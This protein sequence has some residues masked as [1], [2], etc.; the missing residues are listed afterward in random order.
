MADQS[1]DRMQASRISGKD[2]GPNHRRNN[3]RSNDR[4]GNGFHNN[5]DQANRQII[6]SLIQ[7]P[8]ISQTVLADQ[9]GLSQSSV[10]VRL[11]KLNQSRLVYNAI[12]VD[13]RKVGLQMGRA[14]VYTNDSE[15]L[16]TWAES[17]PLLMLGT[18]SV[19]DQNVSLFLIA[20]DLE[21]MN[22]IVDSHIRKMR[23]VTKVR[24]YPI[25]SW[26]KQKELAFPIDLT[27]QRREE[28]SCGMMP[29]CPRC[30][31]NPEYDGKLWQSERINE[32]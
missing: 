28:P 2:D 19:G 18:L 31:S 22:W 4:A 10:A 29:Y 30:P 24:F 11:Q 15:A 23:G 16:L 27:I 14:D 7:D 1:P 5:L 8:G 9:L 3:R 20:E 26:L 21:M 25:V 12:G 32:V 17:C 13:Y 6:R